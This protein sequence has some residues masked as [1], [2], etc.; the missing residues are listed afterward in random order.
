[1]RRLLL[2]VLMLWLPL[3]GAWAAAA[4]YCRH[5]PAA[6]HLGHHAHRH[7]AGA[8]MAADIQ[9]GALADVDCGVCHL[10]C[11]TALPTALPQLGTVP[12]HVQASADPPHF[13]SHI[14]PVPQPPDRARL[15]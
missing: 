7:G 3:Q 14:P 5:E 10:A 2:A 9:S 12:A 4:A 15:A 13:A 11:A 1:M 6:Q 8:P